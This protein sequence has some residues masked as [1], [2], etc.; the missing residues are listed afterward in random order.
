[1]G[2]GVEIDG[3]LDTDGIERPGAQLGILVDESG[4]NAISGGFMR[5]TGCSSQP[6]SY[7]KK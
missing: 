3:G 7:R 6:T 4:P 5:S 1:M 2:V